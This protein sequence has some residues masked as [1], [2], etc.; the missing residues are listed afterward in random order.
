MII[1]TWLIANIKYLLASV[2]VIGLVGSYV[3]MDYQLKS[4][5]SDRD[6]YKADLET[7]LSVNERNKITINILESEINTMDKVMFD[8]FND[9]AA[10]EADRKE[11]NENINDAETVDDEFSVWGGDV[12]PPSAWS[13]LDK[14]R[15]SNRD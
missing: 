8:W 3:V 12:V 10:L 6:Q 15:G 2:V 5:R 14:A 9:Q 1:I 13:V 7:A 4:A 11:S